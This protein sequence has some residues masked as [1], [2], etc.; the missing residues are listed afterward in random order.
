MAKAIYFDMDGTLADL[1]AVKNFR[2]KLETG[3]MSPFSEAH[4]LFNADEMEAQIARLKSEGYTIGIITYIADGSAEYRKASREAKKE[5]LEKYFPYADEI[6]MIK[7]T[8]PKWKVAKIKEAILVDD[9]KANREE[10]K[11]GETIRAYR[12]ISLVNSLAT[13]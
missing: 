8:T 5:W 12:T 3:D 7:R 9:S 6:H 13:L 2:A 10:W 1:F 4:P 11:L